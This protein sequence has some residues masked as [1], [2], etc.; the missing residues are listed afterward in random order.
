[1]GRFYFKIFLVIIVAVSVAATGCRNR[2]RKIKS[3]AAYDLGSPEKFNMPGSL[4]EISGITFDSGANDIIYAIQDEQGK[5]FKLVWGNKKQSHTKF[6]GDGDFEDLAIAGNKMYVLKSN[7]VLVY[8]PMEQLQHEDAD[9]VAFSTQ[10][11][12]SGEYEGM[13]ADGSGKLYVLCK[14]CDSDKNSGKVTVASVGITDSGYEVENV[15]ISEADITV[16]NEKLKSRFQPS[17]LAKNPVTGEWFI[18]SAINKLL[19]ITDANWQVKEAWPLNGNTFNQPEGIAFD[20]V[21]N[22]YISNEGDDLS[23]GNILKFVRNL[24]QP[25]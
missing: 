2:N 13:S 14:K 22:L 20:A 8:F 5:V 1:M 9:S 7:G 16:N 21:G 12:P 4:L 3:P 25:Q 19:V 15:Y 18:I 11:L 6:A 24:K 10:L 23:A 17:A